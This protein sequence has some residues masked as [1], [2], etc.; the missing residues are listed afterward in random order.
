MH[1]KTGKN[2]DLVQ[3]AAIEALQSRLMLSGDGE[4]VDERVEL[5]GEVIEAEILP[6]EEGEAIPEEWYRLELPEGD[7][8]VIADEGE[9]EILVIDEGGE[10]E[11]VSDEDLIFYTMGEVIEEDGGVVE[12][13]EPKSEEESPV[14]GEGVEGEVIITMVPEGSEG[15][16][17]PDEE[18][19]PETVWLTNAGEC[20]V[21]VA[22]P[23]NDEM[24]ENFIGLAPIV[25]EGPSPTPGADEDA[26]WAP[27]EGE[28]LPDDF[29]PPDDTLGEDEPTD[30]GAGLDLA[31]IAPDQLPDGSAFG[32]DVTIEDDVLGTEEDILA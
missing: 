20:A 2:R 17:L 10:G 15:E 23:T 16:P 29:V 12:E 6:L 14:V 31:M 18:L 27:P 24:P 8:E 3:R 5:D 25:S 7:G 21:N 19:P 32:G 28:E 26:R 30:G 13:G 22:A 4:L 9:F 11:V 1:R